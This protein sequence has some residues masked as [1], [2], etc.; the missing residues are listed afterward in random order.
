MP[1]LIRICHV[2]LG[3]Q[4][5]HLLVMVFPPEAKH[6]V[7]KVRGQRWEVCGYKRLMNTPAEHLRFGPV[8]TPSIHIVIFVTL[9]VVS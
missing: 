1:D 8:P 2:F 9:M 7:L 3:V 4:A 5:D 6:K